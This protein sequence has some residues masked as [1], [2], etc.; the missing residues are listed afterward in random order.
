MDASGAAAQVKS[1]LASVR[2]TFRSVKSTESKYWAVKPA[3]R[4]RRSNFSTGVRIT[5]LY[6]TT[7]PQVLARQLLCGSHAFVIPRKLCDPRDLGQ[8]NR[9]RLRDPSPRLSSLGMTCVSDASVGGDGGK[10]RRRRSMS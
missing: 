10:P 8:A 3:R 5:G 9:S 6:R 7:Q 4:V 1:T 2:V